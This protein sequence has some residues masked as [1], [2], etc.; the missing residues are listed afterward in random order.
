[1]PSLS[2]EFEATQLVSSPAA[3]PPSPRRAGVRI[4]AGSTPG[5]TN[6]TNELLASRL[7]NVTIVLAIGSVIFA[8]VEAFEID[9]LATGW[10]QVQWWT[11]LAVTGFLLLMSW[12]LCIRCGHTLKHLRLTEF[13]IFGA[14]TLSFFFNTSVTQIESAP[15]GFLLSGIHP[16]IVL[17][18][19][20]ALYIPNTWQRAAQVLGTIS[21]LAVLSNWLPAVLSKWLPWLVRPEIARLLEEQPVFVTMLTNQS[22]ALLFSTAAAVWGVRTIGLLRQQAYEAQQIGQYRL[23]R[24]LGRGG[25][26]EVHLA[27]HVLLRRPCAI[28]LIAPAKA[29]DPQALARF[30]REV[31]A[32]AKLTHWNT[33]EIYDY[34]RTAEGI[35]YYVM[36]Y[37]PGMTLQQ[38]VEMHGPLPPDR[39]IH[40]IMQACDA[41]QEAH[42]H[43]LV[44]RDIKPANIFSAQRGGVYD[45]VKILDFGLVRHQ[46]AQKEDL[47][48]TQEGIITGSPLFMSPEQASGETPDARSDLYSLGVTAYYL[49]TG[50]VP[51]E[52][53]KP[54]KVILAHAQKPVPPMASRG[55][56][57]PADLEAVIMKCLEK[58][59]GKRFDSAAALREALN[60]CRDAGQWTRDDA[61]D[62]W[63]GHGCPE[64]RALDAEVCEMV[65]GCE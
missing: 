47:E 8:V 14:V 50:Q 53:D 4:V 17:T 43:G 60:L 13:L 29:G 9:G 56:S 58:A 26:G 20:Y 22:L 33:I 30:E 40:L 1:M 21:F 6:E 2:P 54:I 39:V 59:P 27:E 44:H 16:W 34:G 41:L 57:V 51:F 24:L 64:K 63:S 23:K 12:R 52:A 15:L 36:E 35:F 28:K 5:L 18:F 48:L 7:R 37:L 45:V 19:V 11:H 10:H 46:Y 3:P 55:V 49:L 38:V 65:C 61:A 25:M 31:Q 42:D 62:W 32:T